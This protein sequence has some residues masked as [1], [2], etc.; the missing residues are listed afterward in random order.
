MPSTIPADTSLVSQAVV[1]AIPDHLQ[2]P[3]PAE[4]T[5][6]L[7]PWVLP[8]NQYGREHSQLRCGGVSE[9]SHPSAPWWPH[10]QGVGLAHL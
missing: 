8:G 7:L 10:C 9:F 6:F 5:P 4:V 2:E 1:R 3:D